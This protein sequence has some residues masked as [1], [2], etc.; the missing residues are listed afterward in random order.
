MGCVDRQ[1]H[2]TS[3]R[4]HFLQLA[5]CLRTYEG[6][7]PLGDAWYMAPSFATNVCICET[8]YLSQ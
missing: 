5:L 7:C 4:F 3:H 8:L 1:P 6:F 2:F